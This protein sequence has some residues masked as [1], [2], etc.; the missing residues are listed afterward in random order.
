MKV[1]IIFFCI[2]IAGCGEECGTK[3]Q[4]IASKELT[5]FD[6]AIKNMTDS[7]TKKKFGIH[8]VV[9][10][11]VEILVQQALKDTTTLNLHISLPPVHSSSPGQHRKK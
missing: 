3:S 1:L 8:T 6:K 2:G 5:T 9:F 4:P 11:E 7:V 10:D